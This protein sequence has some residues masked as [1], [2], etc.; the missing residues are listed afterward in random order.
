MSSGLTEEIIQ[1]SR[2]LFRKTCA[3]ISET[4]ALGTPRA[5]VIFISSII[6]TL[7]IIPTSFWNHTGYSCIWKKYIIPIFF[8][9]HCPASGFFAGCKCPGC[10]MTHAMSK[11]LHGNAKEALAD[12]FLVY[13]VFALMII[14]LVINLF[15]IFSTKKNF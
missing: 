4:I 15:K 8:N 6:A 11:L 10:N 13:P 2:N 5:I 7:A 12:N 1:M 3:L 9:H 14:L